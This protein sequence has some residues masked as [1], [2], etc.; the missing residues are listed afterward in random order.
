MDSRYLQRE[1]S[2]PLTA[3]V[4]EVC[5]KRPSDPIEY[6]AKWLYKYRNNQLLAVEVLVHYVLDK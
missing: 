2:V 6:I 4:V 5:Q 1:L 3:A